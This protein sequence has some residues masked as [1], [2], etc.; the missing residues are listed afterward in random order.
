MEDTMLRNWTP[1]LARQL[2]FVSNPTTRA[3]DVWLDSIV[4][5]YIT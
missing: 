3:V 1:E 5:G 2:N 4:G